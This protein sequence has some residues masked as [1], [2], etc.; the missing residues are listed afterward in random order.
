MHFKERFYNDDMKFYLFSNLLSL[1]KHLSIRK[2]DWG[3]VSDLSIDSNV[4]IDA[5]LYSPYHLENVN[6]GYGSYISPNSW[7][8]Y[9]TIGKFCSI[10]PNFLSGWGIHPTSAVSTSPMFYSTNKQNGMS[11]SKNVKLQERSRI[12]IGHDVFIG[13][14]TVILDGVTIGNGAVIGAGAVVTAD[15]PPYAIVGGVPAKIIKY[16]FRADQIEKLQVIRWWDWPVVDL[17]LIEELF[18]DVDGFINRF[19]AELDE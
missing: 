19:Y 18:L 12:Q 16:R 1:A 13:T 9:T 3:Y 14:N 11:L 2:I 8:S 10:G 7:I 6:L 5:K 4:D 15:V 17:H